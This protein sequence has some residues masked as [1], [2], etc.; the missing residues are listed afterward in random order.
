MAVS[1]HP[2]HAVLYALVAMLAVVIALHV[3]HAHCMHKL[4][5]LV[6]KSAASCPCKAHK[7]AHG[8][9]PHGQAPLGPA[10]VPMPAKRTPQPDPSTIRIYERAQQEAHQRS[11]TLDNVGRTT[12]P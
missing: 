5:G 12:T 4:H 8:Q 6:S 10:A 2:T 11:L 9:E 1:H 7:A 3:Y